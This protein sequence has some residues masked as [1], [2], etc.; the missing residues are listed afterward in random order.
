M[1]LQRYLL[2]WLTTPLLVI[3]TSKS[4][5]AFSITLPPG[6]DSPCT[7]SSFYCSSQ[8]Y[9]ATN[10]GTVATNVKPISILPLGGTDAFF[11]LL[12]SSV[13]ATNGWTFQKAQQNLQGSFDIKVY[14]PY[15]QPDNPNTLGNDSAV[16]ANIQ[17]LYSPVGTDP[18]GSNVHWIQ[19]V[20]SNHAITTSFDPTQT[21]IQ[22]IDQ[23]HGTTEKKIDVVQQQT[24]PN[25]VYLANPQKQTF[26]PFYN[27]FSLYA[28]QTSFEDFST[29][30]DITDNNDW[31]AQLYLVQETA[32][33][34]VTIYN[35]IKWGWQNKF[36]PPSSPPC[37]GG[38]GG[39][40]CLNAVA[41]DITLRGLPISNLDSGE[42]SQSRT[43]VS[44]PI[45][46]L[47]LLLLGAWG[48]I[49]G[50]KLRKDKH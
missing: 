35:G 16:G 24:Q 5:L 3:L 42:A 30:P 39:G 11:N 27:T 31:S 32:P 8:S 17:I 1:Q 36:T 50:L 19:R 40:G 46:A 43:T 14:K 13:W 10:F 9:T 26:N 29:R 33:K 38:C 37:N 45:S 21:Q 20:V 18:Q 4:S 7:L 23:G 34:T 12:T 2:V 49:Q 47:G 48:V 25:F 15:A 41:S 22:I 6:P 28:N 44:E